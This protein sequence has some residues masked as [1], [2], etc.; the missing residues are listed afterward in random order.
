MPED[1]LR[2][3]VTALAVEVNAGV[4]HASHHLDDDRGNKIVSENCAAAFAIN[5]KS[6]VITIF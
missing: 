2:A 6:V 1:A 4:R 3:L 5:G